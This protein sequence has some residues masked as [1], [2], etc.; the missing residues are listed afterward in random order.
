MRR[1]PTI[2]PVLALAAGLVAQ[3]PPAAKKTPDTSSTPRKSGEFVIH[4]TNGPDQLLSS[5]RGKVVLVAFMHTTC[6]HC[7][8]MAGVLARVQ[9]EYAA[10]GVQVLG[11]TFDPQA[12]K[13]VANFIKTFGVNYPCGYAAEDQVVKFL[14]APSEGYYVPILAFI[15]RTGTVRSQYLVMEP[16]DDASKFLSDPDVNVRKEL[17]KYLKAPVHAAPKAAPKA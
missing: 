15:D 1:I 6:E 9:N 2:F 17:D 16:G 10:K 12:A 5:Y 4:M 11:V 13:N 14:H 8:H 7:Q 3:T